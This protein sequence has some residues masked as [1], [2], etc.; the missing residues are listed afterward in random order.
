MKAF[1]FIFQIVL[2]MLSEKN[3]AFC[4]VFKGD[5][6]KMADRLQCGEIGDKSV[7]DNY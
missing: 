6:Y 7:E 3:N 4:S 2:S 1:N 5:K